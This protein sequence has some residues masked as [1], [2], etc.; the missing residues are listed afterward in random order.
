M[1]K[2]RMIGVMGSGL[3]GN[4]PYEENA[5]SGS[6]KCFFNQC[7]RQG[8]LHRAFGVEVEGVRRIP[9]IFSHFSFNRE[10]WRQKFY[11]D[12]QYYDLLSRRIIKALRPD[13]QDYPLLQ[14]G[15]I[16]DLKPLLNSERKIFSYHDGNLAQAIKSPFFQ[17]KIPK[18]YVERAL[19]YEKRVYQNVDMIFTMSDYL[20]D[21]FL[22]DFGI[23][24]QKVKTIRAGINLDQIP[25]IQEKNYD[26]LES[27]IYWRRF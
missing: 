20:R 13:D 23:N 24:D 3:I 19:N 15:G 22:N 12:T 14:I 27:H 5:W 1:Q 18:N 9:L 8:Y 6:S 21:S 25:E 7:T 2:V 10:I 26:S 16:Y 17:K 4:D 11:L